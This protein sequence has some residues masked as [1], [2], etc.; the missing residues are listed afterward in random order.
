MNTVV[1]NRVNSAISNKPYASNSG[2]LD[3]VPI[4]NGSYQHRNKPENKGDNTSLS[5]NATHRHCID[6]ESH[7]VTK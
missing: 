3:I 1:G 6:S 2:T 7:F 5:Y 4:V